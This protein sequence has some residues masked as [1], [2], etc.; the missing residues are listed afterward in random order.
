MEN[1]TMEQGQEA[2]LQIP[3]LMQ[4]IINS[5]RSRPAWEVIPGLN[6]AR[7]KTAFYPEQRNLN[8][9]QR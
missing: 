4:N 7:V 3:S 9:Q 2:P 6:L 5:G 8:K 1:N